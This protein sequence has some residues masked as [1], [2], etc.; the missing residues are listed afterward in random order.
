MGSARNRR[1]R[2]GREAQGHHPE[3]TSAAGRA[4]NH[5]CRPGTSLPTASREAPFESTPGIEHVSGNN[6]SATNQLC[7]QRPGSAAVR[8]LSCLG[9]LSITVRCNRLLGG[10]HYA[11]HLPPVTSMKLPVVND[12]SRERSH[13]MAR[14]TSSALPPRFIGTNS[15]TRSTRPGSP[16]LACISV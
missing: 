4:A 15:L 8:R 11:S 14:A 6:D 12:A 13:R 1:F 10:W 9:T 5:R 3:R 2:G 16:P 7:S